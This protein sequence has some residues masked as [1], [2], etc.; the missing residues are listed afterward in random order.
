MP[1]PG[2]QMPQKFVSTVTRTNQLAY[3]LYVPKDDVVA[4]SESER[5]VDAFKKA[6]VTDIQLTVY[7]DDGHD[8]WTRAYAEPTLY[9]WLL[10][11]HR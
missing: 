6:G 10:K 5:M 4:P 11:H 1:Q 7:P 9:D 8:S 3:L 2:V